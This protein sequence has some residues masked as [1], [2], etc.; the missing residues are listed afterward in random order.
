MFLLYGVDMVE[1][2]EKL[3]EWCDRIAGNPVKNIMEIRL[4][5][6]WR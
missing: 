6:Q 3:D 4:D 1:K 5:Y 2:L